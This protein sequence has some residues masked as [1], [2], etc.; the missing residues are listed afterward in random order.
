MLLPRLKH[1]IQIAIIS[2]RLYITISKIYEL[3]FFQAYPFLL[4]YFDCSLDFRNN[5]FILHGNEVEAFWGM[6]SVNFAHLCVSSLVNCTEWIVDSM[7]LLPTW[8]CHTWNFNAW[9]MKLIS[10]SWPYQNN[11]PW[12]QEVHGQ[13]MRGAEKMGAPNPPPQIQLKLFHFKKSSWTIGVLPKISF[14]KGIHC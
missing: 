9:N 14:G 8:H 6:C 13:R 2:K 1:E 7:F 11:D 12:S 3:L 10:G 4:A 5:S